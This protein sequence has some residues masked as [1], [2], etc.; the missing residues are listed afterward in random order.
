AA[1]RVHARGRAAMSGRVAVVTGAASGIGLGVARQLAADGH[2]VALLDRERDAAEAAAAELRERRCAAVAAQV[3]VAAR[4]A[5]Q[6]AFAEVRRAIGP[7]TILVTSAG[8]ESF[9]SV[10]DI[11]PES[12]ERI[13]AVNLSG[14]FWCA[15]AA[16]PDMIAAGWGRI[17]TISSSS[18]QS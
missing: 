10:L 18:A 5:V 15:Q 6:R 8:I 1:S 7:V 13:L 2:A 14:T 9:E 12:W 4:A 3:D 17:V 11:A 16:I